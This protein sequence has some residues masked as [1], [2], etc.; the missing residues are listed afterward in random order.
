MK[1]KKN[2]KCY[3]ITK[4]NGYLINIS[5]GHV[6]AIIREKEYFN[7]DIIITHFILFSVNSCRNLTVNFVSKFPLK[8]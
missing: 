1:G 6:R 7:L 5:K 8:K 4:I 3:F 2:V